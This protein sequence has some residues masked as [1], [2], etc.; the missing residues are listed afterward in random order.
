MIF[1]LMQLSLWVARAGRRTRA[2]GFGALEQF[3]LLRSPNRFHPI[4]PA[5]RAVA[6]TQV[7]TLVGEVRTKLHRLSGSE[8]EGRLQL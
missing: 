2:E 8:A 3:A 1:P 5:L 4:S 7:R 6:N